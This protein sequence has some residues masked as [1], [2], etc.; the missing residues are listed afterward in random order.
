[1]H[2]FPTSTQNPITIQGQ[3]I[4]ENKSATTLKMGRG[5]WQTWRFNHYLDDWTNDK[6]RLKDTQEKVERQCIHF[7]F[8]NTFIFSLVLLFHLT[9]YLLGNL[10]VYRDMYPFFPIAVSQHHLLYSPAD[11]VWFP[12]KDRAWERGYLCFESVF[13]RS[14]G[15]ESTEDWKSTQARF[16]VPQLQVTRHP[17]KDIVRC[18]GTYDS[19]LFTGNS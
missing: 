12:P 8:S 10:F 14:E 17:V 2:L 9:L 1:M 15:L 4:E 13:S 3:C 11:L 6:E 7:V 5:L 16:S 18:L 19:K